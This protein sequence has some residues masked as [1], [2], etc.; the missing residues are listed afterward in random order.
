MQ[1]DHYCT[2]PSIAIGVEFWSNQ[3]LTQVDWVRKRENKR[4]PSK[5]VSSMIVPYA[6][7]VQHCISV[8]SWKAPV[9]KY[10][11]LNF[12]YGNGES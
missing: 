10:I 1:S 2:F 12:L 11:L 5:V 4:H 9:V 7:L 8:S 3:N 6:I